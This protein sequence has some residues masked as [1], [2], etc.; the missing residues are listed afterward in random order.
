[1]ALFSLWNVNVGTNIAML[2]CMI[3][4]LHQNKI[5]Y[6]EKCFWSLLIKLQS[7]FDFP[8][9]K[10]FSFENF[11]AQTFYPLSLCFENPWGP[12]KLLIISFWIIISI[13]IHCFIFHGV[14][15]VHR[16]SKYICAAWYNK[17][18]LR[19]ICGRLHQQ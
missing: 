9:G 17:E 18:L 3:T 5:I 14:G 12:W 1:M 8:G 11:V 13:F 16:L 7:S 2:H 10:Q 19:S 6:T 15:T 4:S